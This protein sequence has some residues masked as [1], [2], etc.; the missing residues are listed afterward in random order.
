MASRYEFVVEGEPQ[1]MFRHLATMV[2]AQARLLVTCALFAAA[3]PLASFAGAADTLIWADRSNGGLTTLAYGPLDP[4]INP[5]FL[6]SCFSD[7]SIVVLDVHKEVVG[8]APGKPLTIELSS[9]K[10]QAPIEGEVAQDETS[11]TTFGE[12]SDI[13][14]KPLLDVLRDPGS[15][16]LKMGETTATLSGQGRADAVSEFSKNCTIE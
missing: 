14:V 4:A 8:V 15:L 1:P 10:T 2:N 12:A 13:K 7:M 11:G 9:T 6:L 16:T 3:A 5:L